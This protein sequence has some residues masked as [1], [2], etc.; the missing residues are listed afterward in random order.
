MRGLRTEPTE[1]A[2]PCGEGQGLT[3]PATAAARPSPGSRLRSPWPP[4]LF[5]VGALKEVEAIRSRADLNSNSSSA[6][7]RR[8][9]LGKLFLL[10]GCQFSYS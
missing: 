4:Q 6:I 2:G 5:A 9:T 3:G 8:V 7:T 10:P 1:P